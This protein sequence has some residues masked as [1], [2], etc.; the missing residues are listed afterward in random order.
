[1]RKFIVY[2]GLNAH[3]FIF[4]IGFL[5][6]YNKYR[7]LGLINLM[8]S[9]PKTYKIKIFLQVI[10]GITTALMAIDW[11]FVNNQYSFDPIAL[12]YIGYTILWGLSIY[13]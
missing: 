4:L 6:R 3:Y 7:G 12:I 2:F 8:E 10:M 5:V 13:L 9:K 11:D 1:L